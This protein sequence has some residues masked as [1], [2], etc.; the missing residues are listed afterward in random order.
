MQ[1]GFKDEDIK[2][3]D[4]VRAFI[5]STLTNDMR[6]TLSLSKNGHAG[7]DLH[8][9]WQKALY[10]RGWMAPNW[11]VEYGGA[12]FTSTQKYIFESEMAREGAPRTIPFGLSMVAPVIM[13]FGSQEQKD[14]F[15]PDILESNVWW[16]QGY[17]EPGSGSD[18]A[19]LQCK[20]ENKGD[21]YLVNGTK[22][23][24][25][26]AQYADWIFC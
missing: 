26:M 24:T 15:L 7:K 12:G 10:E 25:T 3:R 17:S 20:A 14:K 1:L 22:I 2:F 9:K 13:E 11:P 16:C 21:H 18:L 4:E 19:S 6:K 8:I 5:D 23:W